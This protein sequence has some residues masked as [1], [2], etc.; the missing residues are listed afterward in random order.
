MA[1]P[2]LTVCPR[3]KQPEYRR[4]PTL[5]HTNL[6]EF[7]TPIEMNSIAMQDDGEIREFLR[8]CPDVRVSTD[9]AD[10]LYGVPVAANRAQKLQAL[11]A[12][13]FTENN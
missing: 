7:H 5:P 4:V 13:G 6:I 9:S 10:P 12:A 3:C 1:E 11:K 2:H 8:R